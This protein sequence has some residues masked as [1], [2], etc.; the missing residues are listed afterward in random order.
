M[1][2]R[3]TLLI[4]FVAPLIAGCDP[5]LAHLIDGQ[6][7]SLNRIVPI[8]QAVNDPALTD[9]ERSKLAYV[10]DI[11]QYAIDVIGL[12]P[13]D[14]YTVFDPNGS[15]PAAYVLAASAQDRLEPYVWFF[16]IFGFTPAK[17]FFDEEMGRQEALALREAGWDVLYA[18]ADG[19]STLGLFPDPV[20]QSNLRMDLSDFAEL[21]MH[22][23]THSTVFKFN[24]ADFS[25]SMATFV[26]RA[27]A[28]SWFASRFGDS[29]DA[30]NRARL[31]WA[32]KEIL[33]EYVVTLH[34]RA[35]AFYDAAAAD[36]KTHDQIL[37]EREDLFSELGQLFTSEFQPRLNLPDEWAFSA[38]PTLDNAT[39]LSGVRYQSGLDVYEA[40]FEAV[41]RDFPQLISVLQEAANETNSREYLQNWLAERT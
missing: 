3:W 8:D 37:I 27:A 24:D 6:L 4:V 12:T 35:Q 15:T 13:G 7:A 34:D 39:I 5:Y 31:R 40:V 2:R 25:E 30:T 18:R 16:P 41:G 19:F 22:E 29:S 36:G 11:R 21:L 10:S 9:D 28:E 14:A 26:G 33:D 20:R 17:G 38:N 1:H 23:M 32:D